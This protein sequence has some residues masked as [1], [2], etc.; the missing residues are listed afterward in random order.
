MRLPHRCLA[1]FIE[2]NFF[3]IG[4]EADHLIAEVG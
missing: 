4:V 1:L 2:I 3:L